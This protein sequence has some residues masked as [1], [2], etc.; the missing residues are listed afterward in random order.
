ME[1]PLIEH[2]IEPKILNGNNGNNERG[3]HRLDPPPAAHATNYRTRER[4]GTTTPTTTKYTLLLHAHR[5][6]STAAAQ[7][8][9]VPRGPAGAR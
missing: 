2:T 8:E 6:Q 9:S 5:P 7:P 4:G 1:Q 3:L